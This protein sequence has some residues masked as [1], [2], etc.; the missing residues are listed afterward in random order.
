[1]NKT[2][3]YGKQF[4]EDDDIQAVI[5]VLKSDWLTQGP[6]IGHFEKSLC[7]E[8]GASY[9][10]VVANGTAALHL[11]GVA[12]GWVKEDVVLTTPMTFLATANCILYAG[13]SP[14]F[15]DIDEISYTIDVNKLEDKVRDYRKKG[16]KIKA[17]IGVDYAGH[18]CEWESLRFLADKYEFQLIDDACH[19]MGAKY[20]ND[21]NYASK[22]ADVTILSFHP[23]KH[24]TTGEGGAVLTKSER[25]D[26]K[27]KTLRTHGMTKSKSMLEKNDG[28]WYYEMHELGFNYRITDI[29]CALGISQLKKLD[30]FVEKRQHIAHYYDSIFVKNEHLIVPQTAE[31]TSHAYHIYPLQIKFDMISIEKEKLF[32]H[33]REKDI[34]CQ[35]HYIPIHLQPY[36]KKKFGFQTGDFP[37]AEKFY[38]QEVSIPMHPQLEAEDL[39]Y[40]TKNIWESLV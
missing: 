4:I 35:V 17:V 12:L 7:E 37:V 39:D 40:V 9:A 6:T 31:L 32:H 11:A 21:K 3:S 8:L 24:I 25:L 1:M 19:A 10:S 34:F 2:Y 18:P 27:I 30:H 5:D 28:P 15:V 38:K 14:D 26:E 22:Y 36:Y 16:K 13:A 23:V 33:L 29:Q 20:K